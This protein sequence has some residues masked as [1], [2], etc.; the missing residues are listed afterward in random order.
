M[1]SLEDRR[2]AL[3]RVEKRLQPLVKEHLK[4]IWEQ[5]R[6]RRG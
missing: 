3:D 1:K 5:R 2:A 4:I 6:W